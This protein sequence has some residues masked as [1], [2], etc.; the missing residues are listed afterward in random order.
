MENEMETRLAWGFKVFFG[1]HRPFESSIISGS[2]PLYPG[3]LCPKPSTRCILKPGNIAL[4]Q[5][6]WDTQPQ[7]DKSKAYSQN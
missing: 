2:F 5:D 6:I 1:V 4:H 7:S 3:S